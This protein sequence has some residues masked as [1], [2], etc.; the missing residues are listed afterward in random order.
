MTESINKTEEKNKIHKSTVFLGVIVAAVF[1]I[2]IFSYQLKSTEFA[3]ISTLGH[4][5]QEKNPGLHFRWPYPIQK[6]YRFD[7]R[8]RCFEGNVG[9][10]EE[11]LTA[12]RHNIIIGIFAIYR[13]KNP[14]VLF[15]HE[16]T[17]EQA[18][19]NLNSL[20]RSAKNEVVGRYKFSDFVN[21][22]NNNK[23][24][25]IENDIRTPLRNVALENYGLE[26]EEIGIKSLGIPEKVT[27]KVIERMKSEREAKSQ[28]IRQE[29]I[30]MANKIK[31]EANKE[32]KEKITV[33][34]AKAKIIRSEG[35]ADAA[36]YYSVFK[37]EPAL[38]IFLKKLDALK[39][40]IKNKTTLIIDTNTAPFDLLQP[41]AEKLDKKKKVSENK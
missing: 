10:L 4:V 29:G 12:D 20:M 21:T 38:A 11:T 7:N 34:T 18:E 17:I 22:G 2:V 3:V 40:I 13:I 8:L 36:A 5:E 27:G 1:L 31:D 15:Q 25:E 26:I 28:A 24:K 19:E 35:D 6:I 9:K 33:A 16:R 30:K 41:G 37:E 14:V 39:K 32:Y 23:L